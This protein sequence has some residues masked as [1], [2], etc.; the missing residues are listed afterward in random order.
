MRCA[1]ARFAES[2][3]TKLDHTLADMIS[4]LEKRA[5]LQ[6]ADRKALLELPFRTRVVEPHQYIVREGMESD[7]SCL[8]VTG[9]AYRQKV[10]IEGSRQILSVHM[11]GDF[12][13]LEGSLLRRADHSIQALT[14][15]EL[16]IV[17]S[18]AIRA[19]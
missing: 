1:P 10:T 18:R 15:C 4:K 8:I 12:V 5:H 6:D 9:F 16:A 19:L 2:H 13:D 7:Q 14:R 11:A 17:P 3:M